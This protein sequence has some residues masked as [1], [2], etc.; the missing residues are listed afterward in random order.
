M[1]RLAVVLSL[2]V[3]IVSW[4]AVTSGPGGRPGAP[5]LTVVLL[6]AAAVLVI[7]FT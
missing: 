4:V 7:T 3:P 6:L 1:A 2:A 5:S